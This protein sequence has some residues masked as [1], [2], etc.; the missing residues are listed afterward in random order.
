MRIL[1]IDPGSRLCGYAVVD[2]DPPRHG[3]KVRYVECGV[4]EARAESPL[5]R[6]L[7]EIAVGI[8]E[9]V[10]ELGPEQ[11]AVEEVFTAVNIRSALALGHARGVALA[12]CGRAGLA[13]FGYPPSVVKQAVTGRGRAPKLQVARMVQVLLGLRREPRADAA[14]AL[15]VA[16]AHANIRKD[17]QLRGRRA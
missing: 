11:A 3:G 9:I 13:V 1:G 6:R 16:V 15:A 4:L 14:D 12:V 7:G 10:D 2:A 5:E 17:L 8:G